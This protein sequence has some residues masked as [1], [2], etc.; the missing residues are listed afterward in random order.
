MKHL[1]LR[2]RVPH[3]LILVSMIFFLYSCGSTVRN[4]YYLTNEQKKL[5]PYNGN[6][7][8]V[9]LSNKGDTI[10]YKGNGCV[11]ETKKYFTDDKSNTYDLKES[12]YCDESLIVPK[13]VVPPLVISLCVHIV[14]E[15]ELPVLP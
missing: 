11:T 5:I 4:E 6:E 13:L 9:F 7:S 15:S 10:I 2:N 1:N 14:T 12:K 3:N 8:I